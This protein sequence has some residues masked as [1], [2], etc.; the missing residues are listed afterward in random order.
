MPTRVFEDRRSGLKNK[1]DEEETE[2]RGHNPKAGS[3]ARA[4]NVDGES[5]SESE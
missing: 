2:E 3:R 1:K 5:R 4:G